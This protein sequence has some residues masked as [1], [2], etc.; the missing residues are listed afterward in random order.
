MARCPGDRFYYSMMRFIATALLGAVFVASS[1]LALAQE[2]T[3]HWPVVDSAYGVL[4][5][6]PPHLLTRADSLA[7]GKTRRAAERARDMRIVVSVADRRLWVLAGSDTLREAEVAVG[8]GKTL[9][10]GGRRWTFATPVGTHV[11]WAKRTRTHW[12]APDWAYAEVAKEHGLRLVPMPANRDLTL[13]DGRRLAVRDTL[14]GIMMPDGFAP[15]PVDEHIVF[16]DALYVPPIGTKNRLIEGE[17]GLYQLDLGDGYLLHGTPHE[18]S[19]GG[20]NTH[21]CV[22]LRGED[23]EW[24]YEVVPVGTRVYVY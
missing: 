4:P 8:M 3:V 21:G 9:K 5:P 24:L 14:V 1:R 12:R 11:V 19:I 18:D 15:L 16:G 2:P 20:A 22:R 17:L 13:P 23:I 10:Y 7:S 6:A